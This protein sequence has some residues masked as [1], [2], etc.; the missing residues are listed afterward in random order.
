MKGELVI[1]RIIQT[2]WFLSEVKPNKCSIIIYFENA[3][4]A[5]IVTQDLTTN[6]DNNNN[7]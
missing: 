6:N 1:I 3:N 2:F 4:T 5:C 7:K